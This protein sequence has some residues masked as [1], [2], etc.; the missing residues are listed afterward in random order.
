MEENYIDFQ[1]CSTFVMRTELTKNLVVANHGY[2]VCY[3]I[4][5]LEQNKIYVAQFLYNY[6]FITQ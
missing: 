6:V 3:E 1:L 4:N 5:L 2:N